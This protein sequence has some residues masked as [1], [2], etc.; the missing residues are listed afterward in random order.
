MLTTCLGIKLIV[1]AGKSYNLP[2]QSRNIAMCCIEQKGWWESESLRKAQKTIGDIISVKEQIIAG[3][4]WESKQWLIFL[5]IACSWA[6]P[7]CTTGSKWPY[8]VLT[9]DLDNSKHM[10]CFMQVELKWSNFNIWDSGKMQWLILH[11]WFCSEQPL[12]HWFGIGD[13]AVSSPCITEAIH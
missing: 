11:R 1:A 7:H 3:Q 12:H 8:K 13:F 2:R 4:K 6:L 5:Q 10:K 9:Y